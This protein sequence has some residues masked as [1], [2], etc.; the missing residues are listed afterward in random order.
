MSQLTILEDNNKKDNVFIDI[1]NTN[2][3][4]PINNIST[5]IDIYSKNQ[6]LMNNNTNVNINNPFISPPS[7]P[8]SGKDGVLNFSDNIQMSNVKE[9]I[10][11]INVLNP[12]E[13]I[14]TSNINNNT[15]D[16]SNNIQLNNQINNDNS[17]NNT[18]KQFN[19]NSIDNDNEVGEEI[20]TTSKK[21][22]V[23]TAIT[24]NLDKK[25]KVVNE[26]E[27]ENSEE[28]NVNNEDGDKKV[29]KYCPVC[30]AKASFMCS[31]CGPV[32][33][34]CSQSC[35]IAH[36]PEHRLVCKG[37]KKIKVKLL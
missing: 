1:N 5:T 22:I 26:N 21:K 6:N 24:F 35:Q 23:K 16:N 31:S 27:N 10:V 32:I 20:S 15:N 7:T 13:N 8:K 2:S 18:P 33:F 28:K 3:E 29:S 12:N 9:E 19:L 4:I 17:K 30:K 36:W 25:E 34:Y 37:V 14:N 11:N